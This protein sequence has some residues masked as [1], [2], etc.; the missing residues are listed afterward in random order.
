MKKKLKKIGLKK[1]TVA[2]LN[3]DEGKTLQGGIT[4]KS[5]MFCSRY[6]L[7]CD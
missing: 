7:I 2:V 4:G 1:T 3:L 5:C 6:P